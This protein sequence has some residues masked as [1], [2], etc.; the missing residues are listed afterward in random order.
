[1]RSPSRTGTL[2]A[3]LW[4]SAR[5]KHLGR[6][7]R[8]WGLGL[9]TGGRRT[10][11]LQASVLTTGKNH[12]SHFPGCGNRPCFAFRDEVRVKVHLYQDADY[13]NAASEVHVEAE[14]TELATQPGV[15][16]KPASAVSVGA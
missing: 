8:L 9:L 3:R 14:E 11:A 7:A 10:G 4:S 2:C 12:G 15:P 6:R 13:R 16:T 5:S 1:M